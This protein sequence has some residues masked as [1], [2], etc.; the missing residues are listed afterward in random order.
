[1]T[2][3]YVTSRTKQFLMYLPNYKVIVPAKVSLRMFPWGNP[4]W[5]KPNRENGDFVTSF[6]HPPLITINNHS[7]VILKCLQSTGTFYYHLSIVILHFFYI[8]HFRPFLL[9]ARVYILLKLSCRLILWSLTHS[10]NG[11]II[12]IYEI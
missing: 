12:W 1:M 3:R 9:F 7:H 4:T 11:K 5:K 10:M 6:N 8:L 2:N